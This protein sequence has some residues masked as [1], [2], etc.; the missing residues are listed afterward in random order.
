MRRLVLS[1]LVALVLAAPA[2]LAQ[3]TPAPAPQETTDSGQAM[4]GGRRPARAQD[5]RAKAASCFRTGRR[6]S[7]P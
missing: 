5:R 2:L 3:G 1:T 4:A 6:S 7:S